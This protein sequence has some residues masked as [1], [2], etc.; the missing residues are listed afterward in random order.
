MTELQSGTR[1]Q[2][3]L[4]TKLT[5]ADGKY[6]VDT[7][8]IARVAS[9][10]Y[11]LNTVTFTPMSGSI[12]AENASQ[13]GNNAVLPMSFAGRNGYGRSYGEVE[14]IVVGDIILVGYVDSSNT[15]PIVIGRYPDSAIAKEVTAQ[16]SPSYAPDDVD[17]YAQSHRKLTVYPD[18]TYSLHDGS[19]RMEL[20]FSGNSFVL[21]NQE[22]NVSSH[23][24]DDGDMPVNETNL[25]GHFD[26]TWEERTPLDRHAPEIVLRHNGTLDKDGNKDQHELYLYI[27][28]DGT[29]RTSI[30]NDD[31]DWRA[32]FEMTSDGKIR[33][34]RQEDSKIFN[35]G[36][37]SSE[38][39]IDE[40]GYVTV[41]SQSSGLV[42][43]PDGIYNL[44]GTKFTSDV[45]LSNN[46]DFKKVWDSID[47]TKDGIKE[48]KAQIEISS[49]DIATK[50]STDELPAAINNQLKPYDDSLKS[51]KDSYTD[52]QKTIDN[53]ASDGVISGSDKKA[54]RTIW[55]QIQTEYP[56]TIAQAEAN[57]VD[58]TAL[59][60]AYT[61]LKS[62][63]TPILL[64]SGDTTID[65]TEW[66]RDFSN[67]YN[68][69][70]NVNTAIVAALRKLAQSG[71]D[72]A[73]TAAED[74]GD[75]ITQASEAT[76]EDYLTGSDKATLG[77]VWI[78]IQNQ[79]PND[80]SSADAVKVDH[81]ALD[82]AY[83]D[84]NAY[85]QTNNIFANNSTIPIDGE[86][87][88]NKIKA[89]FKQEAGVLKQVADKNIQTLA[90]YGQDI[91]HQATSIKETSTKIA[92][93]AE[94]IQKHNDSLAVM[95][96]QLNVM[97]NQISGG[98]S[99]TDV[100]G[101]VNDSL[102]GTGL[103]HTNQF[104]LKTATKG[105]YMDGNNGS[106]SA[107]T[108][109]IISDYVAVNAG[110]PYSAKVYGATGTVKL[111]VAWY[112]SNKSFISGTEQAGTGDVTN[113]G[114]A[115]KNASYAKV[116]TDDYNF[117]TLFI[118]GNAPSEWAPS[119]ADAKGNV[120]SANQL[121]KSLT[122]EQASVSASINANGNKK[123]TNVYNIGSMFVN[124]KLGSTD[125]GSLNGILTD[126][127][128][129]HSSD[130]SLATQYEV[131]ISALNNYYE[132][133][134]DD[135]NGLLGQAEGSS[136]DIDSYRAKLTDYYTNRDTFL[137]V[138][139]GKIDS[140][141][142]SA[143]QALSDANNTANEVITNKYANFAITVDG[144]ST[145]VGEVSETAN[146]AKD[147]AN[148]AV[149]KFSEISQTA[150]EIKQTV[151][152]VTTTA[153]NASDKI[154]N[155]QV[156]GTN[157]VLGTANP[158]STKG[159]NISNEIIPAYNLVKPMGKLVTQVGSPITISFD[160]TI[161]GS[162]SGEIRVQYVGSTAVPMAPAGHVSNTVLADSKYIGSTAMGVELKL[163]NFSGTIIISNLKLELG[164]IATAWSPAPEDNLGIKSTTTIY[165]LGDSGTTHPTGTWTESV[166]TLVKGMYLWTRTNLIYTDDSS[167]PIYSV[168]YIAKDGN[169]GANGVAGKDG[170]GIDSTV[171]DYAVSLNGVTKPTTGWAPG[172]PAVEPGHFLWTRTTWSYTDGTNEVGYSVAQAGLKGDK[173][174]Q[175]L[176]GLQGPQGDQGIQGPD[177]KPSY[178][179]IAYANSANGVTNF[180][181]SDSNRTYIGMY[182]DFNIKDS[183]TPSDYSWT[184]VKGA[185]GSDGLP[186]KAGAD[187]R[188]PYF[189]QAWADSSD[190]ITNFSTDVSLGK[191]YL[192]TYTDYVVADSKDPKKYK[193]TELVG[194]IKIGGTNLY[195][196]SKMITDAYGI[197][198]NAT[199]TVET[200]DST[201]N[202]WHIV[203][204]QATNVTSG[205]YFYNYAEGKIPDNSY[206][207]YSADVKGTGKIKRFGLEFSNANPPIGTVSSEW[208]RISQTGRIVN[209]FK[210]LSMYFDCTSSPLDVYIKLPKLEL[211]NMA[212]AWS[213]APE[214][215][216]SASDLAKTNQTVKTT[217]KQTHDNWTVLAQGIGGSSAGISVDGDGTVKI[218]GDK[219]SIGSDLIAKDITGKNITGSTFANDT[220]TFSIDTAGNIKGATI[221]GSNIQLANLDTPD[222]TKK[223]FLESDG[224][225]LREYYKNS[226]SNLVKTELLFGWSGQTVRHDYKDGSYDY[227]GI[228]STLNPSLY[229]TRYNS[230]HQMT[231]NISLYNDGIVA[232]TL[233]SSGKDKTGMLEPDQIIQ[234]GN[235]GKLLWS[236]VIFPQAGDTAR[237]SIPLSQTQTGWLIRWSYYNS[238]KIQ[239]TY[240]NYTL[241]PKVA[242]DA[243][244]KN[245]MVTL[246]M[247]GV[248]TFFKRLWYSDT[249]I[250]GE[251]NNNKGTQAPH[252][253]M[254]AVY[255]V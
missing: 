88:A 99:E 4:G 244:N 144:I 79:Y 7:L 217:V 80:V 89:Y 155:L 103:G 133:L 227:A 161:M 71:Y 236:G 31:Q 156:G 145:K 171:I 62:Y 101:I 105:Q 200:F 250:A 59:D 181:T 226:N 245:M 166:P 136:V 131:D 97:A 73:V 235:F 246:S 183:T 202:M 40:N 201:T 146:N 179:H 189:H 148:N 51:L 69:S 210:T 17:T 57:H 170:V 169:D 16:R 20:T 167:E 237:M 139:K 55:L 28:Q 215:N 203:A 153:N 165:Q 164:N 91:D 138:V 147:A 186:G 188:T 8:I 207:S 137:Q 239:N 104:V 199:V 140:Q 129:D 34:R 221:S 213:P 152:E 6:K 100:T 92:L 24:T 114:T 30:M 113:N 241:L 230:N 14:P 121:L 150:D 110:T 125:I 159:S 205:V 15:N 222:G 1:L 52:V 248:G 252:A 149:Q 26:G 18:Q 212:T 33:L 112:D 220:G 108:N 3:S 132:Q 194:A 85:I 45:D 2:S 84:L 21:V 49:H 225:L 177:G 117:N 198:G 242:Q 27:S 72:K 56:A 95:Q 76:S 173:G 118:A 23:A 61:T 180:S 43:R 119:Y 35:S 142:S 128:S 83:N 184:L 36:S 126:I 70:Y 214:D 37:K 50:V 157:L 174:D 253:V 63:L 176:Q 195:L 141:V 154:N 197:N 39:L 229:A 60:D 81:S 58:H 216:A 41:R 66:D 228:D 233:D 193:W 168:T 123:K 219:L 115:P 46:V 247:P 143:K 209:E 67:Y 94:N 29:Y 208:S 13:G 54:T 9:I 12:R 240:Y 231:S 178:T 223:G 19:G 192:G 98:V 249:D 224:L 251:A 160:Y 106:S 172:I 111:S 162:L 78:Q 11:Q 90:E 254:D 75:A 65:S 243:P 190:G 10:N 182:V 204:P 122:D 218:D 135:I 206:W 232:N 82:S 109:G 255:A 234:L 68:A 158:V 127:S 53:L 116:S 93:S 77:H 185:D 151:G 47:E 25:A 48:N 86:T 187:G 74:A 120:N 32:Y 130:N 96:G 134:K 124:G 238:S 44:D 163:D 87:L 211:G 107:S 175:G 191:K 38:L 22:T 102:S 5:R 64:A 196:N 42:V